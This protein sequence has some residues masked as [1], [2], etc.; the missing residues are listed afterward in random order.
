MLDLFRRF[1]ARLAG[2]SGDR[3]TTAPLSEKQLE[4][5]LQDGTYETQQLGC[6]CQSV[7]NS[8]AQ[9]G[10]RLAIRDPG[11]HSQ[12]C[13]WIY[14]VADGWGHQYGGVV[15]TRRAH[16]RGQVLRK[17]HSYSAATQQP[18][19]LGEIWRAPSAGHRVGSGMHRQRDDRDVRW[20]SAS[21]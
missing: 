7:G 1:I 13:R 4:S 17:F 6:H 12:A 19:V 8:A 10:Q 21:R 16:Y 9:W 15:A 11:R 14:I 3:A 2:T 18:G 5:I 20:C